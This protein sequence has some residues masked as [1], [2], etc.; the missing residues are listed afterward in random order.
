[1]YNADACSMQCNVMLQSDVV[2]FMAPVISYMSQPLLQVG[3]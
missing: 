1:M 3:L 2:N